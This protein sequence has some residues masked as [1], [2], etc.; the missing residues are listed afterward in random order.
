MSPKDISCQDALRS[1]YEYL[2]GELTPDSA[3]AV[4]HHFEI[5]ER[6]YPHLKFTSSF[7]DAVHRAA[8]SQEEAPPELRRKISSILREEGIEP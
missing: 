3:E 1:I 8:T 2:D 7:R 6:C 4:H 5:C